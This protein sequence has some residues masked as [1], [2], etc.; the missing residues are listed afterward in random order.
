MNLQNQPKLVPGEKCKIFA[1]NIN[2]PVGGITMLSDA[3]CVLLFN[4][5]VA[6]N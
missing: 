1:E 3:C 6:Q 4:Q 2:I 5:P